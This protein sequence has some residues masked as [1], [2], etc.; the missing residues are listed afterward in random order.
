MFVDQVQD[1]IAKVKENPEGAI[2]AVTE[3]KVE[4]P[5]L[6]PSIRRKTEGDIALQTHEVENRKVQFISHHFMIVV[7]LG[8]LF[9]K[10]NHVCRYFTKG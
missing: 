6:S 5:P 3:H 8:F 1:M 10:E 4:S 9:A 7:S 2:G